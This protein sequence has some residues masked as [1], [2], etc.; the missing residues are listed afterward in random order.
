MKKITT[1]FAGIL[2][3]TAAFSQYYVLPNTCSLMNPGNLNNDIEQPSTTTGWTNI[4]TTSAT[5][6]WSSNATIP[7][8]FTFNGTP[9]TQFKVSTSGVLTF[10]LAAVTAPSFTNVAI[11][12]ASVPNNAICVWGLSTTGA[13]D[14]VTTKTFGTTPYRQH[15]VWFRSCTYPECT[16]PWTYWAIVLEETTN[17]IY[18]V[19]Q[20]S[21][22]STSTPMSLTIG[23]QINSTTAYSVTG[24]PSI[25]SQTTTQALDTPAD[26]IWYELGAGTLNTY[27]ASVNSSAI[28][29]YSLVGT[30]VSVVGDMT[31]KGTTTITSMNVNYKINAGAPV[32]ST[33]NSLNIASGGCYSFTHPTNWTP[34]VAGVYTVKIWTSNIN[35]NADQFPANDTVTK[36]V[37]IVN[38]FPNHVVVVEE[39]TGTWCGWCPRGAVFMEQLALNHPG[40][41]IGIAVH[42]ADPMTVSV[43]D[44]G[45][46]GMIG[47]YPSIVV[48]RK[49]VDDPSNVETQFQNHTG[50]FGFASLTMP[51]SFNTSTRVLT[52]SAS[53][54]MATGLT[55]SY[56]LAMVTTEDNVTGTASTYNQ[57]NY[58]S[59]TSQNLPLVGAGHNWQTEPNPVP[60][61]NM[62]YDHVARSIAGGF[63]GQTGSLP[64]VLVDGNTYTY[65]F[66]Y[67]VPAAYNIANMHAYLILID[68]TTGNILNGGEGAIT[69]GINENHPN[70]ADVAVYPNPMKDASTIAVN[71]VSA[72][73]VV[74]SVYNMLG[75]KSATISAGMLSAGGHNISLDCSTMNA[76]VYFVKVDAGTS[77]MSTKIVVEK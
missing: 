65:T 48:D 24:S 72:Q 31:N 76:G 22:C 74:I 17:K 58:Y 30:P 61:A 41:A 60:A 55:G 3:T 67:T 42:N 5:P 53:C 73:N 28:V 52:G 49:V 56:R 46:S 14:V 62:T 21:Y 18:V 23:V 47:G 37:N 50:D 63:T 39:G 15:W 71:L 10:D 7:F 20:R 27:D 33:L 68:Q 35:G 26:N 32:T 45:I 11:P 38:S 2:L 40:T 25:A 66:T 57:T 36:I 6:V 69:V 54:T 59:S 1:L 70:I 8:S 34:G 19:D 44:A 12:T 64:G 9:Y 75:E 4:A 51:S 16:T 77:T 13:N 43:Y 29:A